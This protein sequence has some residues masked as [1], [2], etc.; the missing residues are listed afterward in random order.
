MHPDGDE[1]DSWDKW[2]AIRNDDNNP[3][4]LLID[5]DNKS[6]VISAMEKIS[7]GDKEILLL[8]HVDELKYEEISGVLD[9]PIGTVCTRLYRARKNLRVAM[10]TI[11]EELMR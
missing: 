3:E 2:D 9:V 11:Q 7:P 1:A 4:N 6:F 5:K 10:G 8:Y